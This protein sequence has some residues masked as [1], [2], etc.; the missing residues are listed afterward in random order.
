MKKINASL[1]IL[2]F[3]L[4]IPSIA[5]S[6]E[7]KETQIAQPKEQTNAAT[8]TLEELLNKLFP[9]LKEKNYEVAHLGK[10]TLISLTLPNDHNPLKQSETTVPSMGIVLESLVEIVEK[11]FMNTEDYQINS[12]NKVLKKGTLLKLIQNIGSSY[13]DEFTRRKSQ[14]LSLKQIIENTPQKE[15]T[16]EWKKQQIISLFLLTKPLSDTSTTLAPGA[17]KHIDNSL[18]FL[19][20]RA[21]VII[22]DAEKFIAQ[23]KEKVDPLFAQQNTKNKNLYEGKKELWLSLQHSLVDTPQEQRTFDWKEALLVDLWTICQFFSQVITDSGLKIKALDEYL[24][25]ID[26]DMETTPLCIQNLAG[27]P[28]TLTDNAVYLCLGLKVSIDKAF[29]KS[30]VGNTETSSLL[31]S[32]VE[33]ASTSVQHRGGKDINSGEQSNCSVM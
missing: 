29:L 16:F 9:S 19:E 21:N 18:E 10:S 23:H 11:L 7:T 20:D 3:L 30:I 17:T 24:K 12:S 33:G 1:G 8:S 28:I 27:T 14:L 31:S 22:K 6:A 13:V 32:T 5:Q 15:K 26:F 25:K 2:N 4:L